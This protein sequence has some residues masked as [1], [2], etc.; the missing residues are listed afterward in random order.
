MVDCRLILFVQRETE[1][2]MRANV[3]AADTKSVWTVRAHLEYAHLEYAMMEM[4]NL[5]KLCNLCSF[6]QFQENR[7]VAH[8]VP[9]L[10]AVLQVLVEA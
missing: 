3:L 2:L 4:V 10:L 5:Y 7:R 1:D 9:V 6:Q 8:T